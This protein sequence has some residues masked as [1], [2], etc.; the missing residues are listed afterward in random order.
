MIDSDLPPLLSMP[1]TSQR[2]FRPFA[3]V[4]LWALVAAGVLFA[5]ARETVQD[6]A[7]AVEEM[8]ALA[9]VQT[10]PTS[11]VGLAGM[12]GGAPFDAMMTRVD[13][14][15]EQIS[16]IRALAQ[17]A[18]ADV[19]RMTGWLQPLRTAALVEL[20]RPDADP[21]ALAALRARVTDVS[22]AVRLRVAFA[23]IAIADVLSPDQRAQLAIGA[24]VTPAS[25]RSGLANAE[26]LRRWGL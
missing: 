10:A 11:L 15:E 17:G 13:A 26:I 21:Q 4:A 19:E 23:M 8:Q 7:P 1:A 18:L 6:T 12:M 3:L 16:Q 25:G 14:S 2:R 24:I 20:S 9:P 22:E 5:L